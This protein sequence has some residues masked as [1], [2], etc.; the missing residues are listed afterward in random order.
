MR[1]ATRIRVSAHWASWVDSLR[2]INSRHPGVAATLVRCLVGPTDSRHFSAVASCRAVLWESGFDAPTSHF[3]PSRSG[4]SHPRRLGCSRAGMA[5]CCIVGC[6]GTFR[7]HSGCPPCFSCSPGCAPLARRSSLWPPV[8]HVA[9]VAAPAVQLSHVQGAPARL[10][11]PL[12]LSPRACR[13]GHQLDCL[14]HHRAS[15]SRAGGFLGGAASHWSL[16]SVRVFCEAGARVSANV[17]YLDLPIR[18]MDQRRIEVIAEG[19][20]CSTGLSWRLTPRWCHLFVLMVSHTVAVPRWMALPLLSPVG[21]RSVARR[22]QKSRQTRRHCCG[23]GW[24][25]LGADVAPTLGR[26]K[27][28]LHPTASASRCDRAF[29]WCAL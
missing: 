6:G 26:S 18:A 13:C 8:H 3:S 27:D 9:L 17:F 1:S 4:C 10:H 12:P 20:L 19:F 21:A 23:N 7:E 28:S 16:L 29:V 11:V 2:M 25:V 15:C 14:G 5:A 22:R 24:S